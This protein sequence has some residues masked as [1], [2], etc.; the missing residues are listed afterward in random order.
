MG[1]DAEKDSQTL[2]ICDELH[3]GR[4]DIFRARQVKETI[5]R[6]PT[7]SVRPGL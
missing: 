3:R 1:A 6:W 5:R 4:G 7:E 2:D